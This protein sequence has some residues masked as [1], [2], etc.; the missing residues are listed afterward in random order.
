MRDLLLVFFVPDLRRMKREEINRFGNCSIVCNGHCTFLEHVAGG[1]VDPHMV[2][3]S[4]RLMFLSHMVGSPDVEPLQLQQCG[5]CEVPCLAAM[6]EDRLHN[7]LVDHGADLWRSVICLEDLSYPGPCPTSLLDL[8]PHCPDV[9][10]ILDKNL[11][12]VT[13]RLNLLQDFPFDVK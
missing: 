3:P 13:K 12:E 10:I 11:P 5:L 7:R 4:P 2:W 9:L 1:G 6:E 8:A